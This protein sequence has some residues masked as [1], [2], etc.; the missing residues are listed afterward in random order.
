[1]RSVTDT[2]DFTRSHGMELVLLKGI[3]MM[4]GTEIIGMCS[5]LD[6]PHTT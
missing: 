2:K 3:G 6:V 1:M 4:Y 5:G